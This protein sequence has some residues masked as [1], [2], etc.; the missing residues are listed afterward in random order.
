MK[1]NEVESCFTSITDKFKFYIMS[2]KNW[3]PF[4]QLNI[5]KI[6]R[7]STSYKNNSQLNKLV[8]KNQSIRCKG[9]LKSI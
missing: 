9:W 8:D 2:I 6:R 7:F 3:T 1:L 5:L 4:K